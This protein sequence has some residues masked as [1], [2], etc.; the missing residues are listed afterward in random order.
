MTVFVYKLSLPVFLENFDP[1]GD[2]PSDSRSLPKSERTYNGRHIVCHKF[3]GNLGDLLFQYASILG[4]TRHQNRLF[5]ASGNVALENVLRE[6]KF[7]VG[8]NHCKSVVHLA[9]RTCCHFDDNVAQIDTMKNYDIDGY[10][11]SWKYFND[12]DS[13]VRKSLAFKPK[14]ISTAKEIIRDLLQHHKQSSSNI[15][16]IG[17]HVYTELKHHEEIEKFGY[18]VAPKSYY[19]KAMNYFSKRLKRPHAFLVVSDDAAWCR[20]NL[21]GLPN[22]HFVGSTQPEVGLAVLSLAE[23]SVISSGSVSWWAGYLS[24]GKVVYFKDFA[25]ED[26]GMMYNKDKLMADYIRPGWIP[27]S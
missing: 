1:E 9:E 13:F 16:L 21:K 3:K 22:V 4:M 19:V 6:T 2:M 27:L 23:H 10:L 8:K 25:K 15:T 24:K 18:N 5:L 26:V 7:R 12:M 20:H 11:Q 17:V 14:L